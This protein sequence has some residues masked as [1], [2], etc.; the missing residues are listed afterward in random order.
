MIS[1]AISAPSFRGWCPIQIFLFKSTNENTNRD[2]GT[3]GTHRTQANAPSSRIPSP[4]GGNIH[5]YPG[6]RGRL[7]V[8]DSQ[9]NGYSFRPGLTAREQATGFLRM[10]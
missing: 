2:S 5:K 6:I 9:A 7:G 1:I 8:I 10:L 4:R 3:T